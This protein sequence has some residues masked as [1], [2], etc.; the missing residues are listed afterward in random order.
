MP[1][2]NPALPRDGGSRRLAAVAPAVACAPREDSIRI[3][4][5]SCAMHGGRRHV[6]F[7]HR[8]P[9]PH[10]NRR[11]RRA[12]GHRQDEPRRSPAGPFRRHRRSGVRRTGLHRHR[13]RSHG[14]APA[15]LPAGIAGALPAWRRVDPPDRHARV[16]GLRGA[17]AV[18]AGSR[19]HR[20]HRHQR[21]DRHR[22]DGA[23]HDGLGGAARAVPAHRGQQDRRAGGGLRRARRAAAGGVREGVPAVEPAVTRWVIGG[24]LLL[25]CGGRSVSRAAVFIGVGCTPCPGRAGGGGGCRVRRPVPKRWGRG[26]ARAARAAGAG[27]ARG[28]PGADL[29]RV[30]PHGGRRGRAAR[31]D[32]AAAA[33]SHR[34]ES[35]AV[36]QGRGFGRRSHPRS[37]RPG[38][39]RHRPRLQGHQRPVRRQDG[40]VPHPPGHRHAGQPSLHR[41]RAQAVQGG[42]PVHAAG[43]GACG[44]ASGRAGGSLCRGEGG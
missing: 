5:A 37:A 11:P 41:R 14:T 1:S 2:W 21:A 6:E 23:A 17:C 4:P 35:A 3:L 32:R 7:Q 43:E 33:Q 10:P 44:G 9:G 22:A 31:R 28:A 13:P 26:S 24:R 38:P 12:D 30:V 16:C 25:Q 40:G 36:P 34:R 20:R 15:A 18:G 29:L 8:G 27:A 42:A 39:A 19:G